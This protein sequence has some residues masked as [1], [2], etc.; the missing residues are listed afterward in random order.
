M[1]FVVAAFALLASVVVAS[2]ADWTEY[3]NTRFGF[4]V[5]VPPGFSG[6]ALIDKTSGQTF[7][8]ADS[9]QTLTVG[10]GSVQPGSFNTQW[11]KTQAAY[12]EGGWAL[13][14]KP[15]A[16]NWTVFTGQRD[17]H[18]LPL[19]IAARAKTIATDSLQQIKSMGDKHMLAGH[20]AYD[21]IRPLGEFAEKPVEGPALFLSIGLA[22]TEVA[23]L[24]A[25][26]QQIASS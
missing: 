19:E 8:S 3:R 12:S 10:G 16:P 18:E 9:S 15:V 14:Y 21:R 6:G 5:D 20:E 23:C 7:T 13:T 11:E 25:A 24:A 22:G 4:V 1:R 17:G 26:L 2:A